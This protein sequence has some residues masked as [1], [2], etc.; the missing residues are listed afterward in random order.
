MKVTTIGI[1]LAKN[2]LARFESC[3]G[4]GIFFTANV[5]ADNAELTPDRLATIL[6]LLP[7]DGVRRRPP[8]GLMTPYF[9]S[10]KRGESC[11]AAIS[12]VRLIPI[13]R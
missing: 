6:A 8:Q 13:H 12:K 7:R 2:V 11:G 9:P 1:D 5:G 3:A 4:L 10:R